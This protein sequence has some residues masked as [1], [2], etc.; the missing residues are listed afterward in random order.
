MNRAAVIRNFGRLDESV[1]IEEIPIVK[2]G[3]QEVLVRVYAAGLNFSD[4]KLAEGSLGPLSPKVR[5]FLT[6]QSLLPVK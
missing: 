5:F 4:Y 1:R 2:P 6:L 3:P